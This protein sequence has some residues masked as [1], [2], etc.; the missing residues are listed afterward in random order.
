VNVGVKARRDA[1]V[2]G[3]PKLTLEYTGTTPAGDRPTRVFAQLV[4]EAQDVVV[5]NQIT[6]IAVVLDGKPHTVTVPLEMIAQQMASG[7][8]LTLQV[9]AATVAYAPPRF[10]GRVEFTKIRIELP[11]VRG[12]SRI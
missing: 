11:V 8:S 2:V 12:L 5:G 10:G 4:D 1:F 7:E 6:P 3:A 9:V